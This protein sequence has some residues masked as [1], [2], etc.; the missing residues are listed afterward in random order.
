MRALLILL[1]MKILESSRFNLND[2]SVPRAHYDALSL[3]LVAG[4][5]VFFFLEKYPLANKLEAR[6][7]AAIASRRP[8]TLAL[9]ILVAALFLYETWR[10]ADILYFYPICCLRSDML[11]MVRGATEHLAAL[12]NPFDKTYCPW[13]IPFTYLP[14]MMTFFLPAVL[15]RFDLRFISFLFFLLTLFL[16]FRHHRENGRPLG[17]FLIVL[18]M[19]SSPL[20]QLFILDVQDFPFLFVI[21][22]ALYMFARGK[23]IPFAF[24]LAL[25]LATRQIFAVLL[26]F[27][28]I[29]G[30]K[31]NRVRIPVIGAFS[32]GL[33]AGFFP[34]LLFPQSFI[35]NLARSYQ[36]L[37]SPPRIGR[38]LVHSLGLS[39]Y[40]SDH[41][42]LATLM[43][44]I[45]LFSLYIAAIKYL[46]ER[47]LWLFLALGLFSFLFFTRYALRP[48]EYYY[49][50][51][52][53]IVSI[54]P[55]REVPGASRSRAARRF[56]LTGMMVLCLLLVFFFPFL[57]GRNYRLIHLTDGPRTPRSK[58][59][60][61]D[62]RMEFFLIAV[63]PGLWS[64]DL[65]L[66]IRRLEPERKDLPVAV[67]IR[68][69]DKDAFRAEARGQKLWV[70][71]RQ[72]DLKKYLFW[73][74]NGF[75]I[76]LDEP[77]AF[78]LKASW[79][80]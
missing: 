53:A 4:V 19:I 39:Y 20:L 65:E 6:I 7:E 48:E 26:P 28:V 16:I 5:L 56:L 47:N 29:T 76:S 11:P 12:S 37:S 21:T 24:C 25:A 14:M 55:L 73:G 3:A 40:F 61:P 59:L 78:E 34:A 69:N 15:L 51:L 35:L 79:S 2:G 62:G 75:E 50:P 72:H 38:F 30:W 36:H 60:A 70:S 57:S 46:R 41:Q 67:N 10:Y 22:L 13:N 43:S 58:I 68:I 8:L 33:L 31:A 80:R 74:A 17:G 27:F 9:D 66:L 64:Q 23:Y 54:V 18:I 44:I 77:E 71:T 52:F 32:A 42:W 45:F 63:A 49:L 1:V